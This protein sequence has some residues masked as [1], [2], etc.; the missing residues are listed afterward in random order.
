MGLG[1]VARQVI[2]SPDKLR[3]SHHRILR[4]AARGL[5]NDEI[6]R[7]TG[8]SESRVCMIRNAPA[9]KQVLSRYRERLVDRMVD[10][11]SE[12]E[13]TDTRTRRLAKAQRLDRLVQADESGELLAIRDYNSIITDLEDRFGTPRK[14]TNLN[15][16]ADFAAELE[17]AI[18]R[19]KLA[20]QRE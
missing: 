2:V 16:H 1:R 13:E 18:A 10:S 20:E 3:D 15:I 7:I 17:K 4:L 9:S 6:S 12:E 8:Y 14:S 11:I 19:T 5:N